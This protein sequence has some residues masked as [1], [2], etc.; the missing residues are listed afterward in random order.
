VARVL[1]S[2][3]GII[4]VSNNPKRV[5]KAIFDLCPLAIQSLLKAAMISSL[6]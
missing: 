5:I 3:N 4:N 6:V 2:P 1:L